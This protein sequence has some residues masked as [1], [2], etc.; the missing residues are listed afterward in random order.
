MG[1]LLLSKCP[2]AQW[3]KCLHFPLKLWEG[4]WNYIHLVRKAF[5]NYVCQKF[6]SCTGSGFAKAA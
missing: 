6:R 2:E 3:F 1:L 5:N 4:H